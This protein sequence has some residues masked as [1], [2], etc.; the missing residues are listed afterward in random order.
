M[1]VMVFQSVFILSVSIL[2]VFRG[3]IAGSECSVFALALLGCY[4]VLT[5][6]CRLFRDNI[7]IPMF[8]SKAV[9]FFTDCLSLE[10]GTA[11]LFQNV[12]N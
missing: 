7:L 4:A 12:G 2:N 3:L 9:Q 1:F 5:D 6:S 8:K 11:R 10:D